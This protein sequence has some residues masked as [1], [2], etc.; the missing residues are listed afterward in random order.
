MS[1]LTDRELEFIASLTTGWRRLYCNELARLLK[2][3]DDRRDARHETDP[4]IAQS[5]RPEG[6]IL[7]G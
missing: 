6:L 4:V 7:P 3:D 5:R 1:V 2:G